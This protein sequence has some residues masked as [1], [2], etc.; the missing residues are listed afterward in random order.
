[1]TYNPK[2]PEEPQCTC[3][4]AD[5]A[6][7]WLFSAYG[8]R[9]RPGEERRYAEGMAAFVAGYHTAIAIIRRA[10]HDAP[11]E[12]GHIHIKVRAD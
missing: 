1:M 8:Q 5:H 11:D 7:R 6:E 4:A 12:T 9:V 10:L 3:S 2:G